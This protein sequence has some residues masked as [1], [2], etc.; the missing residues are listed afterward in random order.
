MKTLNFL[1]LGI[2]V[3]LLAPLNAQC[4]YTAL[5]SWNITNVKYKINERWFVY[6]E[7]QLR[8]L[9]FYDDFHYFEYSGGVNYKLSKNMN[10]AFAIGDYNTFSEGGN[11][12]R[13]KKNN[14]IRTGLQ[15]TLLQ[16]LWK[17]NIEH[18]YRA[19][20]RFTTNGFR[21]RF[22]YRINAKVPFGKE[23]T[24][25]KFYATINNEIFFTDKEPYFERN[26]FMYGIGYR[27]N[28]SLT[29][30]AGHMYQFDYKIFDETG[31]GFF[32]VAL[33]F[34]L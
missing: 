20:Q 8:S 33:L 31:R 29:V 6:G 14:E 34:E 24:N 2:T 15:I 3:F 30:Q 17:V 12:V 28:N 19:E 25:S 1:F 23:L 21:N 27:L 5:G 9:Q 32:Q 16:N 10:L 4:Q 26:R 13:P 22:R 18:R 7:G 11:F